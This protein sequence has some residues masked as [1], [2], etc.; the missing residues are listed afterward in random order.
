[1]EIFELI[2]SFSLRRDFTAGSPNFVT[3]GARHAASI[4][5]SAEPSMWRLSILWGNAAFPLSDGAHPTVNTEKWRSI[6]AKAEYGI[7]FI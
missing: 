3:F 5:G 7:D 6:A 2:E 4:T 1:M